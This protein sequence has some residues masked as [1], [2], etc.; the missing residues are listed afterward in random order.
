[1]KKSKGFGEGKSL[2][3]WLTR[4]AKVR[5]NNGSYLQVYRSDSDVSMER[6]LDAK[7]KEKLEG[8]NRSRRA[9]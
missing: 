1:V 7:I 9:L 5:G 6:V 3:V 4:D 2:L 8:W